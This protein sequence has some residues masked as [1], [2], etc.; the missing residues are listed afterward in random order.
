[1]EGMGEVILIIY[2]SI[3]LFAGG[4]IV[5]V[6]SL[7]VF[8]TRW[9]VRKIVAGILCVTGILCMAPLC[10]ITVD[11]IERKWKNREEM[12]SLMRAIGE[13][14][15]DRVNRLIQEGYD[16]NEDRRHSYPSIPL[17]YA[18]NCSD[19]MR[20]IRLLVENGAD[21]NAHPG[22]GLLPLNEAI[23]RDR[24]EWVKYLLEHGADVLALH[25]NPP[26]LPLTYA[27]RM[28]RSMEVIEVLLEHG[29][30]V[31]SSA[32]AFYQGD[33]NALLELIAKHTAGKDN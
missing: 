5:L 30:A 33:R 10:M 28:S 9:K 14:R 26:E 32:T 8:W 21:V 22:N 11:S 24:A 25:G 18:I 15:Y 1:M 27:I 13:H 3:I 7:A 17:S 4:I 12:G 2:G 31:D 19:D 23:F 16:V 6:I 20:I 29:A